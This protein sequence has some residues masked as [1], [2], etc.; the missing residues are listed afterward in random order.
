MQ[1]ILQTSPLFWRR[2]IRCGSGP[3]GV[4]SRL[5]SSRKLPRRL[6]PPATF[7]SFKAP[8]LPTTRYRYSPQ[9]QDLFLFRLIKKHFS[10][11]HASEGAPTAQLSRT[12]RARIQTPCAIKSSSRSSCSCSS[13]VLY[14]FGHRGIRTFG[15]ELQLRTGP[16]RPPGLKKSSV[17][18]R[19]ARNQPEVLN[20]LLPY[21][22][23]CSAMTFA[24]K[25]MTVPGKGEVWILPEASSDNNIK[26]SP[27][28]RRL[29]RDLGNPRLCPRIR[30]FSTFW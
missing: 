9:H 1:R 5:L 24:L 18:H 4:L 28:P 12:V 19:G 23:D 14:N 26:S 20:D 16:S 25:E 30:V 21:G 22:S 17:V 8:R 3:A 7:S 10:H 15:P 11:T 27:R 2:L 29:H 6:S 13:R